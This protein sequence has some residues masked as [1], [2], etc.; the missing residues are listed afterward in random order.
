MAKA[1]SSTSSQLDDRRQQAL[2]QRGDALGAGEEDRLGLRTVVERAV[3]DRFWQ[4]LRLSRGVHQAQ[5]LHLQLLGAIEAAAPGGDIVSVH[6]GGERQQADAS[7]STRSSISFLF[8]RW[9]TCLII[10]NDIISCH[11]IYYFIISYSIFP[12][13][14]GLE[15]P[16]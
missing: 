8:R 9:I 15:S 10:S 3:F 13:L 11:R 2:V 5:V 14:G 16:A 7:T 1:V 12:K 6:G 4:W